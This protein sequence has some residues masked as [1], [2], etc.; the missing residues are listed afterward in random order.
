[1][2]SSALHRVQACAVVALAVMA[3]GCGDDGDDDEGRSDR[4]AAVDAAAA[5]PV[6]SG[7]WR[8][9]SHCSAAFVGMSVQLTQTDCAISVAGPLPGLLSG[10]V[11]AD[12]TFTLSGA[13]TGATLSCTGTASATSITQTCTGACSVS[14]ER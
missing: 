1:M 11:E 9:A 14:F 10:S 12:G 8:I 5:C 4:D 6:L 3:L 13:V 2:D 7:T